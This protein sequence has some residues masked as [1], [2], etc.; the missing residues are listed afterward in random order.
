MISTL[1]SKGNQDGGYVLLSLAICIGLL[2]HGTAFFHTLESTYDYYVHVFFADHYQKS[3][4]EPWEYRWYTG[5]TLFSYPPLVHQLIALLAGFAGLKIGA[6]IL[7]SG[8]VVLYTVGIYRFSKLICVNQRAAGYSAL[9]GV[10]LPSTVETFHLFGQLPMMMGIAWLLNAIPEIYL[11]VR[12]GK[13]RYYFTGITLIAVAVCSH[14]VTPIFGMVFFVLPIMATAVL[15]KAHSMNSEGL[16]LPWRQYWASFK[17]SFKPIFSFG[18][19]TI[20]VTLLCILPYWIFSKSDPIAQ[21]PIPHGSRDNFFEIGSSGMVFF[22]IPWGYILFLLPFIC[23]RLFSRRNLFI[24][25]SFI[26][27]FVLGTGGT[28]PIPRLLLG[29]NAFSILTLERFTFWATIWATPVLG[30]FMWRFFEGDLRLQL[31]TRFSNFSINLITGFMIAIIFSSAVFAMNLGSFRPTQPDKVKLLPLLNFLN[32]DKHYEW[33]FLTLGFGDQMAWL[34]ANTRALTIDGNYH[35][36][37]RVPELTSKAVERLENS[38]YRGFEGLGSLQEFLTMPEKYH[39]KYVFSNDKFYDPMLYFSGWHRVRLLDNGITIWERSDVPPLPSVL[40]KGNFPF[41]QKIWWGVVPLI[42]LLVAFFCNVQMHWI[43]HIS[44][45]NSHRDD[46]INPEQAKKGSRLMNRIHVAWALLSTMVYLG[47][48][49]YLYVL[50][51]TQNSPEKVVLSYYDAIDFK[52]FEAAHGYFD[53]QSGISLDQFMLENSVSNGIIESYGKL[54]GIK[55]KLV[56]QKESRAIVEVDLHYISPL[57]AYQ[58]TLEHEVKYY[59]GKWYL[60]PPKFT[61][62]KPPEQFIAKPYLSFY[63]QQRRRLTTDETFHE[64][65]LDRPVVH[66]KEAKLV[67][68]DSVYSIIGQLQNVDNNPA[69]I[70]L[71]GSLLSKD[72]TVI[73]T[74]NARFVIMHKLLPKEVSGFRIDFTEEHWQSVLNNRSQ[75]FDPAPFA[76]MKLLKQPVL[77]KLEAVASI[78]KQDQYRDFSTNNV[79]FHRGQVS[80]EVFNSGT[81]SLTIPQVLISYLD[82]NDQLI[83]VDHIL[84]EKT[85]DTQKKTN[86]SSPIPDFKDINTVADSAV[87]ITVNGLLNDDLA[88]KFTKQLKPEP[89]LQVTM[90]YQGLKCR[91]ELNPYV[92]NPGSF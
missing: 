80:G 79:L 1:K 3:W 68:K 86:F 35:S 91:L 14:H 25:F 60:L 88:K 12:Y 58:R 73:G 65:V 53:P 89:E 27:L 50:V 76:P 47:G 74:Y 71:R 26:L 11:W 5:F 66:I 23:Y 21:V 70:T 69:D 4:F 75:I 87:L 77:F 10:F 45:K 19:S 13:I 61:S 43:N 44:R 92:E 8:I 72:S 2:F 81:K 9:V 55:T 18:I 48:V 32:M 62:R 20:L 42:V 90:T 34:S 63:N 85:V 40:P 38:K 29:E 54:N 84:V 22:V 15:D 31:K 57:S 52:E 37:R 33:R 59:K 49:W 41:Y 28:T 83:W 6:W 16:K 56:Q 51:Q 17:K 82:Q 36:A 24:G 67:H 78:T 7:A 30:E 39:L 64:D 46:F